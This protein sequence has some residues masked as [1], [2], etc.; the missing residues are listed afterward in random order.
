MCELHLGRHLAALKLWERMFARLCPRHWKAAMAAQ[1]QINVF[2]LAKHSEIAQFWEQ[3]PALKAALGPTCIT[4]STPW[5]IAVR[6]SHPRRGIFWD[7]APTLETKSSPAAP[8][9]ATDNP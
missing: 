5:E 3:S 8:T 9:A 1:V 2:R 4:L 7:G 6:T